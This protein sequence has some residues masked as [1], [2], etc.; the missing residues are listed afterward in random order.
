MLKNFFKKHRLTIHHILP[1]LSLAFTLF[2]FAPVDLFLSSAEEFWFSLTDLARWLGILALATF[3]LSTLLAWLLPR[4]L[5]IAFR[6]AVY[7]VSFLAWIQGNLLT[8]DYGTLDGSLIDWSAYTLQY[9]LG[10]LLWLTVIGLFIFLMFRF[11]K[12]FRRI[13]E[14]AACILLVTQLASLAFFLVR[15]QGR[16]KEEYLYLS[17]DGQFTVSSSENTVVFIPDTVDSLFFTDFIEQYPDEV[18]E[19]F[20]DFTYYRDTVGGAARTQY[21]VPQILTGDVN[22]QDLRYRDYLKSAYASS[23]L[24]NELASGGYDTGFYTYERYLD[25]SRKDAIGNVAVGSPKP[26]SRVGLTKMYLKLVAFRYA[27]SIFS[28]YFWMYTGDF[29]V[30]KSNAEYT[31]NDSSFYKNLKS[32]GLN[33]STDKPAFRFLHLR[34]LHPPCRLDENLKKAKG[35]SNETRQT[36]GLLKLFSYYMDQL[37]KLGVYDQTT[38]IIMAD[39]GSYKHSSD[40]QAPILLVKFAGASHPFEI[41]ETPLSFF[42][43]QEILISALRGELTSLEPWR[44]EEPRY[45]YRRSEKG[46]TV[47]ITEYVIDGPVYE[48]PAIKTG[49]VFHDGTLKATR[50]YTPGTTVYFDYRDTARPYLVSGVPNNEGALAVWTVGSDVQMLFDLPETPGALRLTMEYANT[51]HGQQTVEVWVND[52]LVGSDVVDG[53]SRQ[54]VVIPEGVVTGTE[55]RLRLHLPDAVSPYTLGTNASDKR[56]LALSMESLLIEEVQD[57]E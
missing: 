7:A 27:P 53:L 22:R 3:V 52:Q 36:L 18:N 41:S 49:V 2:V 35:G 42:S 56:L 28:R 16:E 8:I 13:V 31:P 14:V 54:T 20:A 34:G 23:P 51:Y 4:K 9:V 46:N 48:A 17:K 57:D 45:F 10:A 21:A 43:M 26:S 30:W 6:A 37:K 47:N 29:D 25:L 1:G 5:S 44:T 55:L 11:R 24:M 39:H 38:V 33:V 40:G 15:D 32:K 19:A 12:K 50:D